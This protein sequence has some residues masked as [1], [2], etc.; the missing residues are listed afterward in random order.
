MDA[1]SALLAGIGLG[2]RNSG[3]SSGHPDSVQ[4]IGDVQQWFPS[5]RRSTHQGV[6][7]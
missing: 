5:L 4:A 3:Q 7:Q 6:L 1:T 2:L